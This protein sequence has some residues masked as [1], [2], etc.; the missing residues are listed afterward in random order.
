MKNELQNNHHSS[1]TSLNEMNSFMK[2]TP[3]YTTESYNGTEKLLNKCAVITASYN[4]VGKA[5]AIAFAKEGADVALIYNHQQYEKELKSVV[6]LIEKMGRKVWLFKA[7]TFDEYKCKRLFENI[8]KKVKNIDILVNTFSISNKND[9]EGGHYLLRKNDTLKIQ[10]LFTLGKIA[11]DFMAKD[12]V[13]INSATLCAYAQPDQLIFYAALK[14][15]IKTYTHEMNRMFSV[16]QKKLRINGITTG[17]IW[18]ESLPNVL[19]SYN[20]LPT[21]IHSVTPMHPY[22][23]APLY[24]FVASA[25]SHPIAGETLDAGGKMYK[26]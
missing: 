21:N 4:G 16:A 8:S 12:G 25:A 5:V 20:N 6:K 24:V 18:S 22:E 11:P 2:I 1:T 3:K 10:S 19:P 26:L 17:F 9:T 7:F 15:A 14:A 13:I 23:V